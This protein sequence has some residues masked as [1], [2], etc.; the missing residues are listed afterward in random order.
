MS[1]SMYVRGACRCLD[2]EERGGEG[3]ADD[4][5]HHRILVQHQH[6]D[7]QESLEHLRRT[8]S[9]HVCQRMPTTAHRERRV[10]LKDELC[11]G[12]VPGTADAVSRGVFLGG[13]CEHVTGMLRT[14]T[15]S[16]QNMCGSNSW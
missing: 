13:E 3:D 7:Q 2:E 6:P 8:T 10:V 11:S 4:E 1:M 16:H 5:L 9:A 15:S 14:S 12:R